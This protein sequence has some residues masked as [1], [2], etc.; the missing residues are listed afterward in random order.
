MG[1]K[2]CRATSYKATAVIEVADGSLARGR[3]GDDGLT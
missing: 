3:P 1:M 2:G